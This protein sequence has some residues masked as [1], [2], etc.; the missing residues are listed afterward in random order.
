MHVICISQPRCRKLHL[1][2]FFDGLIVE[3]AINKELI[4]D[5]RGGTVTT[6]SNGDAGRDAPIA[7]GSLSILPLQ[8]APAH[9]LSIFLFFTYL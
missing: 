1:N 4:L 6:P 9:P 8:I 2:T 5:K 3:D 7:P